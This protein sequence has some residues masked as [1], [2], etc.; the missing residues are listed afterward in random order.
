[1]K[2]GDII[3]LWVVIL[4]FIALLVIFTIYPEVFNDMRIM[5]PSYPIDKR[6]F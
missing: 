2:T 5:F 1:M 6:S 4:S 3:L